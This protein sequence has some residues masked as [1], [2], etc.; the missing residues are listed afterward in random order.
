MEECLL[1]LLLIPAIT[2]AMHTLSLLTETLRDK[3]INN[4]AMIPIV[5]SRLNANSDIG[6]ECVTVSALV[7]LHLKEK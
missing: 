7:K 2:G 1:I 5:K 3:S 4:Q 6:D